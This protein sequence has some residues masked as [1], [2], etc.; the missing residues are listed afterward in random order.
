MKSVSYFFKDS[1][2][3]ETYCGDTRSCTGNSG[4]QDRWY[5]KT[6]L[7][8]WTIDTAKDDPDAVEGT[9]DYMQISARKPGFAC[10]D[11]GQCGSQWYAGTSSSR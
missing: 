1:V 5:F 7:A 6:M 2:F 3:Y 9:K 4:L 10:E 8:R 11:S